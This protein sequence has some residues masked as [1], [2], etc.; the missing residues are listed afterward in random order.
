MIK[1]KL[2]AVLFGPQGSGKGTQGRLL[3]ERFDIPFIGVGDLL[4]D[5]IA[6]GTGLGK[7]LDEY[8]NQ[9]L[10]APDDLVN[11][12][13]VERLKRDELSRGFVLDGY[14]R[15]VDQAQFLDRHYKITLAVSLRIDDKESLRRL[16]GR[17]QCVRC[18]EVYHLRSAPPV[19]PGVCSVC[20]GQLAP[21][22]DDTEEAIRRR[23]ATYHF[24]T[25]PLSSYYRQRGALL[26]INGEQSI[27]YVFDDLVKKMAKLGFV[28]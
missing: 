15:N 21:R 20:G 7:L 18:G 16:L 3:A 23:L 26:M 19:K 9:G 5:E 14:P 25:E 17:I 27:P 8:V 6:E 10:L 1:K 12:V 2:R 24:M 22:E 28:A 4:R 11:A 13:I